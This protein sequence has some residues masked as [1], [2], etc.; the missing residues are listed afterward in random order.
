MKEKRYPA[1][2]IFLAA[3]LALTVGLLISAKA[4]T[5]AVVEQ[6]QILSGRL[7]TLEVEN[8]ALRL[9][10]S[11]QEIQWT[12]IDAGDYH[13]TLLVES[14]AEAKGSLTVNASAQATLAPDAT[15][16]ARL[17]LR[18]G[19]EVLSEE[20]IALLPGEAA[21]IFEADVSTSFR[22]PAIAV[23]E[24]VQLWLIVESDCCDDLSSCGAGWYMENG[25]WLLI[26][27]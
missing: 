13:C 3:A 2:C 20:P 27:G 10:Q 12:P 17:E 16:S 21:G 24:E 8:T 23:G 25:E 15:R 6:L 1:L 7:Q 11:L 5:A 26:T 4:E 9:Q 22:L 19:N 14:W 18:L